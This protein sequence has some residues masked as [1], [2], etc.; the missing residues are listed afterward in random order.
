[1][2]RGA[3]VK[4][5]LIVLLGVALLAFFAIY[6]GLRPGARV[7]PVCVIFDNAQG[8]VSGDPVYLAGVQIGEVKS[9]ELDPKTLKA[10]VFL[11]IHRGTI[12]YDTYQF[13][14]STSGLIQERFVDVLPSPE[15]AKGRPLTYGQCVRGITAPGLPELIASGAKVLEN[16]NRTAEL[17][18]TT[19][20]DEELLGRVKTALDRLAAAADA[21]QRLVR[22]LSVIAE[23]TQP[24]VH[25]TL[26]NIADATADTRLA[27]A[28]VKVVTG[29]LRQRVEEGETLDNVEE[30][31]RSA[32]EASANLERI[33][34]QVEK[35]TGD[36]QVQ[37]DLRDT[38]A[39]L[40]VT[41]ATAK[42][43]S[44]DLEVMSKELRKAA[45]AVPR[46][47]TEI[48]KIAEVSQQV[49]ER[50]KP[51][52]IRGRFDLLYSPTSSRLYPSA[53][54][55][56]SNHYSRFLRLGVDDIGEENTVNAQLGDRS[57]SR[58]LRY[59]LIRSQ[60][61]AGIDLPVGGRGV[62]SVDLFDPNNLRADV[63]ATLP[64]ILGSRDLSFV[65]GM[66][67]LGQDDLF[68]VGARFRR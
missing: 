9:V 44:E 21:S 34:A 19:I 28:D 49:R 27:M 11:D 41:V 45:P 2:Y 13:Q 57:S 7:Y 52:E 47:T 62:F 40:R 58:T 31:I 29:E 38:L 39:D 25:A 23:E 36:E 56:F 51:P 54:L 33:T 5:G 46:V 67:D 64:M 60:L 55:D 4:V 17:L 63:T 22:S 10:K 16:L 65:V 50:L 24:Q 26:Q 68:V 61:G 3:E 18:R 8:L 66:R 35:F 53:N 30:L 48:S 43:I 14:V 12:L 59:G 20:S 32:K 1:M 6:L 15:G 37:T 42:R